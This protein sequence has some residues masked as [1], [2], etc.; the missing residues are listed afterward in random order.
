MSVNQRIKKFQSA[1]CPKQRDFANAI[2]ISE[3]TLS[4][5][6]NGKTKPSFKVIEAILKQFPNLNAR[7]LLVGEGEMTIESDNSEN[8]EESE[9]TE[10]VVENLQRRVAILEKEIKE[11][12]QLLNKQN[13]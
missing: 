4:S 1:S 9:N 2:D 10:G 12:K 5:I 11:I 6:Y 3:K 7:W 13:F 8:T